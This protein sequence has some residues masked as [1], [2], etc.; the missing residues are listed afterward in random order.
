MTREEL[1]EVGIY[2]PEVF[3][4]RI[5]IYLQ[6]EFSVLLLYERDKD[7]TSYCLFFYEPNFS[8]PFPNH[9]N[10]NHVHIVKDVGDIRL[11]KGGLS[12]Y[13]RFLS[14]GNTYIKLVSDQRITSRSL[15]NLDILQQHI[16]NFRYG[17][18]D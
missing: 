5:V 8:P 3:D 16:N 4:D 14:W 12:K 10:Y 6:L 2:C 13:I 18:S 7:D 11:Y 9:I 15:N 1:L 17:H